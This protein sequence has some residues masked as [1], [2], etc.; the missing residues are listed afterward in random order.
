[1]RLPRFARSIRRFAEA[2]RRRHSLAWSPSP[3][4]SRSSRPPGRKDGG[5]RA[6]GQAGPEQQVAAAAD[7]D[8]RQPHP[9]DQAVADQKR[10]QPVRALVQVAAAE[11]GRQGAPVHRSPPPDRAVR[12]EAR[13][14]PGVA[15]H[16]PLGRHQL[17]PEHDVRRVVQLPIPV[18]DARFGFELPEQRGSRVGRQDVEGRALEAL[19][20]DPL[21]RPLEHV[22]PVVVE[23][24]DEAPV[25]LDPVVVEDAD[26]PAVVGGARGAFARVDDV[27]VGQ[28]L[29]TDEHARASGERHL[30][31]ERGV[32]RDVD[33]HGGAPDALERPEPAAQRTQVVGFRAQVVVDE[34]R[35]GLAVLDDLR[36]HL[37]GRAHPVGHV[38]PV[39]RE[40][41]EAAAVVTAARGDQACR[42]QEALAREDRT[43]RCGLGRVGRGVGS[44]VGR[45][46]TA[47]LG[48]AQDERSNASGNSHRT[49]PLPRDS[50][51]ARIR[52][53][54][55]GLSGPRRRRGSARGSAGPG[56]P[57]RRARPSRRSWPHRCGCGSTRRRGPGS[58]CRVFPSARS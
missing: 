34:H 26:A 13:V 48:V 42:R 46:Q 25:H 4:R 33:R 20:L 30:P 54:G 10:P 39:R 52:R 51:T 50:W 17:R 31:H 28:R 44:G 21:D 7:L 43:A 29:E 35:E 41:A 14:A 11:V 37:V 1:M 40:V 24:E 12:E 56:A 6:G 38:Q 45:L 5:S 2:A 19:A 22:R 36:R 32:V 23:A 53:V 15:L 47:R 8:Q 9:V 55:R 58:A 3:S 49:G 16:Q 18:Q 27:P 57:R